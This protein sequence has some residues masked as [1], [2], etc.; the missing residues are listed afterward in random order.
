LEPLAQSHLQALK[1]VAFAH[2]DE[3]RLT[4][5]PTDEAQAAAYFGRVLEQ[6]RQGTAHPVAVILKASGRVVGTSRL[7]E[8]DLGH[9]RCELGFSWYD[10]SLFR[11]GVNLDSK[12]LLL[13]FAF[14]SLLLHRVQIHTDTRNVRSQRAIEALGARREGV[15]RR[16]QVAHDGY[17]RDTVVYAI[18]DLDWPEVC[19]RLLTKQAD[20][21]GAATT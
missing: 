7:T 5:T 16:H 15:L 13:K 19:A 14:E 17:V 21:L 2:P 3:F 8:I 20:R 12:I 4:S 18:T 1:E 6:K 11:S 9:R 10:P